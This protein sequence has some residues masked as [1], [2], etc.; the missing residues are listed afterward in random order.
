MEH[1][2]L[3]LKLQNGEDYLVNSVIMCYNSSEI[4]RLTSELLQTS[5]DLVEFGVEAVH[6]FVDSLYT[7][8]VELLNRNIFTEVYKMSRVFKVTWLLSKCTGYYENLVFN[9][10]TLCHTMD[11]AGYNESVTKCLFDIARTVQTQDF[12][13]ERIF[14][15]ILV[16]SMDERGDKGEFI[17]RFVADSK[18]DEISKSLVQLVLD[19]VAAN[20]LNIQHTKTLH[21]AH[22][23]YCVYTVLLYTLPETFCQGPWTFQTW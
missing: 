12:L 17:K 16:K 23:H 9:R 5:L 20:T 11:T 14:V 21:T 2:N 4:K 7:G 15:D 3:K 6:C 19:I 10:E 8:E 13:K 1:C 22:Q 18:L